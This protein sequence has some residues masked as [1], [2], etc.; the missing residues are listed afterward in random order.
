M[1]SETSNETAKS[2]L[3]IAPLSCAYKHTQ[4]DRG[5]FGAESMLV[6]FTGCVCGEGS[7]LWLMCADRDTTRTQR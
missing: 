5:S 2:I 1:G 6:R 4:D 3:S 7:A